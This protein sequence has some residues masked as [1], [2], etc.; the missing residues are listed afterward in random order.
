MKGVKAAKW[1]RFGAALAATGSLFSSACSASAGRYTTHT[2][3]PEDPE[4]PIV[5]IEVERIGDS[6]L[7]DS[8]SVS[9]D[10]AWE[11]DGEYEQ[12]GPDSAALK[13]IKDVYLQLQLE[14]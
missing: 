4:W 12:R 9:P 8:S 13:V 14:G 6:D 11:A 2:K 7:H 5:L 3:C 1:W 10:I